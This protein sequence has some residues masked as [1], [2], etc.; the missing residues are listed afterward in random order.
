[1]QC[2]LGLQRAA[3]VTH[4]RPRRNVALPALP[5]RCVTR[6]YSVAPLPTIIAVAVQ[7]CPS[8]V[9]QTSVRHSS[10]FHVT[11][12]NVC[13]VVLRPVVLRLIVL[14]PIVLSSC[15]FIQHLFDFRSTFV[16]P[17]LDVC[18][19]SVGHL[20]VIGHFQERI[21]FFK[22]YVVLEFCS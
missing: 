22:L 9:R 13:P 7:L 12:S 10:D 15:L 18:L 16:R 19:T 5:Q 14:R 6:S 3:G 8:D 21:V 4:C 2:W 17:L 1:L 11:P 20:C